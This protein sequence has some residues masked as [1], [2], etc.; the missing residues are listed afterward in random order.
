MDDFELLRAFIGG[1]EDAFETLVKRHINAVYSIALR[2]VRSPET[3]EE[4]ACSVFTDLAKS[5]HKIRPKLPLIAWLFRVTRR[6]AL[7]ALRM[8]QRRRIREARLF[9]NQDT[10]S[11]L[12][13]GILSSLDAAL[14]ALKASD[15]NILLLRYF[16]ERQVEE[17]AREIGINPE[18]MQKR[19]E[20]AL[21]RLRL[22]FRRRGLVASSAGLAGVL[23]A[24]VVQSAPGAVI[25][26]V[27]CALKAAHVAG[28]AANFGISAFMST[29]QK[30]TI[31]GIL[32]GALTTGLYQQSRV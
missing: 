1:S 8:E 4:V 9:E 32:A 11:P 30:A 26:S 12:P 2:V 19:L 23:A 31:V 7:D 3:A 16:Q 17:I 29:S 24:G 10:P 27:G 13:E 5:A 28:A 6:T 14:E 22:Y 21:E 25:A 20:R 15:R 18:A